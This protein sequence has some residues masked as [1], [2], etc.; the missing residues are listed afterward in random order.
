MVIVRTT[1]RDDTPL[2]TA[3]LLLDAHRVELEYA[4]KVNPS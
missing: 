1:Y 2:E 3:D 4:L